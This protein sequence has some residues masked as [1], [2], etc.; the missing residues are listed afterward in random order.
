MD[1][2]S[3]VERVLAATDDDHEPIHSLTIMDVDH[4][5]DRLAVI[6]PFSAP[7]LRAIMGEVH[8]DPIDELM[9]IFRRLHGVEAKWFIRLILKDLRPAEIP[10]TLI[11][12]QFHFLMPDLLKIRITLVDA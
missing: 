11:L 4:T 12:Q 8:G 7:K 5:L 6:C 9:S 10:T 2:A 3:A 1:F